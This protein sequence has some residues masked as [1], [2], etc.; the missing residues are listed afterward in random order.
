[1]LA[2]LDMY[3]FSGCPSDVF[4]FNRGGAYWSSFGHRRIGHPEISDACP[5]RDLAP[6]CCW[7]LLKVQ[8]NSGA[9]LYLRQLSQ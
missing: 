2:Y 7:E 4:G 6:I 3:E 9:E 8:L 5:T 1:M